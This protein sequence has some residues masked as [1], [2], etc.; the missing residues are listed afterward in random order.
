[1]MEKEPTN[2]RTNYRTKGPEFKHEDSNLENLNISY[3]EQSRGV[4]ILNS[5]PNVLHAVFK[6]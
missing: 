1:M 3:V 4:F 6:G 2:N 5:H